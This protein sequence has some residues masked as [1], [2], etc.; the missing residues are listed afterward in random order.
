MQTWRQ[1]LGNLVLWSPTFQRRRKDFLIGGGGHVPPVLPPPPGYY[2]YV[3][4]PLTSLLETMQGWPPPLLYLDTRSNQMYW[5]W[6]WS[7]HMASIIDCEVLPSARWG[8]C[9]G[10]WWR[11]GPGFGE[12]WALLRRDL[13][14][15]QQYH[16][17]EDLPARDWEGETG[18]LSW[19]NS[20][21]WVQLLT[22]VLNSEGSVCVCD[23]TCVVFV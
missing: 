1:G 9:S 6:Q 13:A 20:P 2:A 15:W 18:R 10:W 12:L 4:C 8:I 21:R 22:R 3:F 17:R 7:R 11:G 14:P 16:H 19:K 23:K 5:R